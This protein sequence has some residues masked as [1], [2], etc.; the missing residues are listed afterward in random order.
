[1]GVLANGLARIAAGIV[2]LFVFLIGVY[3]RRI[4]PLFAPR[5]R[6]TPSCS[7][8]AVACLKKDGLL[9]G[10]VKAIWRIL[11]CQPFC[12]GGYDPPS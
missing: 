1:M 8:Y 10:L 11:R 5:C 2:R 9:R 7:S 12:S 6:F 4:S 3:Q